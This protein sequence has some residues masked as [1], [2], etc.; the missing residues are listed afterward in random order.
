MLFVSLLLL[1]LLLL[2]FRM[3]VGIIT[4]NLHEIS[5]RSLGQPRGLTAYC[6]C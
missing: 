6:I 3:F 4:E 2:L 1:S 5:A